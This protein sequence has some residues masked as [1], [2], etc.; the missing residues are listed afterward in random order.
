MPLSI[1][2]LRLQYHWSR[3]PI[4]KLRQSTAT[5]KGKNRLVGFGSGRGDGHSNRAWDGLANAHHRGRPGWLPFGVRLACLPSPLHHCYHSSTL[6]HQNG[7]MP[8]Q[9]AYG[10]PRGET[11]TPRKDTVEYC[12]PMPNA[13]RMTRKREDQASRHE[14]CNSKERHVR[15][16]DSEGCLSSECTGRREGRSN[17]LVL[18]AVGYQ[19]ASSTRH[20]W[21]WPTIHVLLLHD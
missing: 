7:D 1:L 9:S 13:E 19:A 15:Q 10:P 20:G 14:A 16:Q 17:C 12:R 11:T 18:I 21:T 8:F 2:E 6:S 4:M 5:A 3:I